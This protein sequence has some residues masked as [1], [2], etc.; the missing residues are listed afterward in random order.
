MAY[1]IGRM[2]PDSPREYFH[3]FAAGRR[4]GYPNYQGIRDNRWKL[5]IETKEDGSLVPL[6]LYDLGEDP[7]ERFDRMA[8]FPEITGRLLEQARKFNDSFRQQL[9]PA[10]ITD[11]EWN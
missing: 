8:V 6:E 1:L 4:K 3:Y 2:S 5:R 10:G 9:R 11:Y 7:S